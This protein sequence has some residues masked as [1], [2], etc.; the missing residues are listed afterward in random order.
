MSRPAL[1]AAQPA[2]LLERP[3]GVVS[4]PDAREPLVAI[5]GTD[6]DRA[7]DHLTAGQALQR[8]L[9]TI[10]DS[11]LTSSMISQPIEVPTAR[12]QLRRSL[13]RSGIPQMALRIGYG[14]SGRPSPRR[15]LGD[16]LGAGN[17]DPDGS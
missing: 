4:D 6:A 5:L 13:R 7:L 15:D 3:G 11:G 16:V 10:T 14:R 8:V 12:E 9:L 1:V 17:A 2:P